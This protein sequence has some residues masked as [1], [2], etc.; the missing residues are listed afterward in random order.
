MSYHEF[1]SGS[2]NEFYSSEASLT[3]SSGT[4]SR[5][6]LNLAATLHEKDIGWPPVTAES[7]QLVNANNFS[8]SFGPDG[9]MSLTLFNNSDKAFS[10]TFALGINN[11][12]QTAVPEPQAWLA[13]L[14]GLGVVGS[15]ARRRKGPPSSTAAI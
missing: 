7:H 12:I 6:Y 11:S 14:L 4:D 1:D 3:A 13:M 2:M 9:A 8:Y 10:G 15:V 5:H